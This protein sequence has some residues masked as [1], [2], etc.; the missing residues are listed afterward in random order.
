MTTPH[1]LVINCGSSSLKFALLSLA[2]QSLTLEGIADRLGSSDASLSWKYQQQ[3]HQQDLAGPSHSDAGAAII[4]LLGQYQLGDSIQ[5]I[6]HRVVHGGEK[7]RSS[8][9][10]DKQVIQAIKDCSSLAPLHNPANLIGIEVC[11]QYFPQLPQV[12]VFD[13]AFHQ[14]MPKKAYLYPLPYSLYRDYGVRRYGFHGTSFRYVSQQAVTQLKLDAS[15]HGIVIAHLGNGA[16][17]CAVHDGKSVDTTMGL[18]PLEGLVMGTRSGNIDPGLFRF[19][20]DRCG[21][22]L[23]DIDKL[24]NKESGLLGISEL[25]NDMRS[26]Q[27]AADTGHDQARLAITVF[28]YVLAKQLAGLATALPQLNA[29]IFTGG[30]GEN[31]AE[32]RAEVIRQLAVLDLHCDERHNRN[33]GHDNGGLISSAQSKKIAVIATDEELMIAQDTAAIAKL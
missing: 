16:S 32:I 2:E 9:L 11:Q 30:I 24:L 20:Q 10:I 27:E 8:A 31:S 23:N 7:F 19:L 12:A 14:T 4:D 18:T 13:T 25:S 28:C 29:L 33:H 21:Y 26:L 5:G 3:K 22:S 17:A 15:N 1:V 6:G